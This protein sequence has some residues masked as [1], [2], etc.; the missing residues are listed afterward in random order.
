MADVVDTGSGLKVK[1]Q[2]VMFPS[3]IMVSYGFLNYTG[4]LMTNKTQARV[5]LW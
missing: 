3:R 2:R 5:R 4:W 1:H